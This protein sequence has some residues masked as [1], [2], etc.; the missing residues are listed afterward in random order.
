[1][2]TMSDQKRNTSLVSLSLQTLGDFT[3]MT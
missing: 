2:T 1:M 3:F